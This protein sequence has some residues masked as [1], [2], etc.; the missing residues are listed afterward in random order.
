MFGERSYKEINPF[1]VPCI[2]RLT[3]HQSPTKHDSLQLKSKSPRVNRSQLVT[4]YYYYYVI[5]LV[6]YFPKIKISVLSKQ[7]ILLCKGIQINF[8]LPY[9]THRETP[10]LLLYYPFSV[11]PSIEDFRKETPNPTFVYDSH[12]RKERKK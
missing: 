7:F 10:K 6:T 8:S 1:R 9:G 12:R 3:I 2:R 11:P 4:N 5:L